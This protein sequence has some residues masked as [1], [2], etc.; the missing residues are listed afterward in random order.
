MQSLANSLSSVMEGMPS[1]QSQLGIIQPHSQCARHTSKFSSSLSPKTY[2][3]EV[4][5]KGDDSLMFKVMRLLWL[6]YCAV[7][8]NVLTMV[9]RWCVK[10]LSGMFYIEI[11]KVTH[12]HGLPFAYL[13]AYE[14]VLTLV[15]FKNIT[16]LIGCVGSLSKYS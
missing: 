12:I 5:Y 6:P 8:P 1:V 3:L 4:N 16:P 13:V 10:V 2:L 7:P 9:K 11:C 14:K 15:V